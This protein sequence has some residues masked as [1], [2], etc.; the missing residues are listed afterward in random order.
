VLV[1]GV[2][3][4]MRGRSLGEVARWRDDKLIRLLKLIQDQDEN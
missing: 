4:E 3:E 1:Q 2:L